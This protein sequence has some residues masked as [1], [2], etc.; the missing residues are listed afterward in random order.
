MNDTPNGGPAFPIPRNHNS[1]DAIY[2]DNPIEAIQQQNDGRMYR[3]GTAPA[4][5][6][7]AQTLDQFRG[8]Y[9]YNLTEANYL[10]FNATG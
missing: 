9:Q 3:N 5:S 8:N 2:A 7:V 6:Q 4:K 10:Q 1:G